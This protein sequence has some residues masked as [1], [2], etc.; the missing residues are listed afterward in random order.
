MWNERES[1]K[2]V[3][4]PEAN[5]TTVEKNICDIKHLTTSWAHFLSR[6]V[7]NKQETQMSNG[8]IWGENNKIEAQSLSWTTLSP[9]TQW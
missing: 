7:D 1:K 8:N 4:D 2:N 6:L 5:I 3:E 9:V